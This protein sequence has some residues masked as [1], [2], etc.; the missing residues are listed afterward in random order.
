M[1]QIV[2]WPFLTLFIYRPKTS[3]VL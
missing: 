1:R 3:T 2:Y